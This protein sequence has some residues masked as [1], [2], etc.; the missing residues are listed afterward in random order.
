M[1]KTITILSLLLAVGVVC[2]AQTGF[3]D[4]VDVTTEKAPWSLRILGNDLDITGVQAKPDQASAYFMMVSESTKLN[5]SVFIEPVDKCKT[6]EECRD[7]VLGLGN[8]AW[9]KYEQLAKG[10]LKDFS[11]FEFYRPEAEGKP[12]KVLDMYAEYVSQGYWV[13]LHI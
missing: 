2:A 7:R 11:Y 8:P 13:D 12:L 9:G 3:V 10:K 4:G 1:I 5:V 6:S